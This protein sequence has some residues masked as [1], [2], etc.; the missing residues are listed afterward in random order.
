MVQTRRGRFFGFTWEETRIYVSIHVIQEASSSFKPPNFLEEGA[1][2]SNWTGGTHV[3][4]NTRI[5]PF[6]K[7][8]AFSFSQNYGA[9]FNPTRPPG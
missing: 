8:R 3:P 6:G 5:N 1:A 9:E 4:E 2:P 7:F